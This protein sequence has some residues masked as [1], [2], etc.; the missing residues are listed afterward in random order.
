MQQ[1]NYV[2]AQLIF[3]PRFESINFYHNTVGL[4]VNIFAK[5]EWKI[6][7]RWGLRSAK[8]F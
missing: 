3:M 2:F 7:E 4:K 5:K 1:A 8:S 6:F